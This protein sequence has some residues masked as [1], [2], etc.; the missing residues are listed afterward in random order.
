MR[1]SGNMKNRTWKVVGWVVALAILLYFG[2]NLHIKLED[3]LLK[4]EAFEAKAEVVPQTAAELREELASI[5]RSGR[6]G[7]SGESGGAKLKEGEVFYT[8]D[9]NSKMEVNCLRKGRRPIDCESWGLYQEKIGTIQHY[10]MRV[11]GHEVTQVEALTIALDEEKAK[12]FMLECAIKVDGCVWN[13]TAAE[14]NRAYVEV[15]VP[16]IRKL[17]AKHNPQL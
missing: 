7:K 15:I 4:A 10:A 12:E 3:A 6:D 5:I 2:T 17:E 11:Y 8:V 16:L 14:N 9:P 13:W 1:S